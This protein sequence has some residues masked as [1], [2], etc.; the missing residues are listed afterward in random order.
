M[1]VTPIASRRTDPRIVEQLELALERAR[2]GKVQSLVILAVGADDIAST[3]IG[4]PIAL[5]YAIEALKLELLS[6]D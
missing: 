6:N 2:C 5:V 4:D 3:F 1:S